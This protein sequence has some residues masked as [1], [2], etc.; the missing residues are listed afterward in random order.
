MESKALQYVR[1]K[2]SKDEYLSACL[3]ELDLSTQCNGIDGCETFIKEKMEAA[4]L[5]MDSLD[6]NDPFWEHT[7]KL[8]TLHKLRDFADYQI[9]NNNNPV[10]A[11]W[12][13]IVSALSIVTDHLN[14]EMWKILKENNELDI[15]FLVSTAFSVSICWEDQTIG[16][17]VKLVKELSL[18]SDVEPELDKLRVRDNAAVGW[19]ALVKSE[20][21]LT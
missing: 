2:I 6:R 13:K 18:E 3:A 1:G 17:F 16:S 9:K 5:D 19:I 12:L 15:P 7:N 10:S 14:V 21:N 8:P 4:F 11:A 20:L